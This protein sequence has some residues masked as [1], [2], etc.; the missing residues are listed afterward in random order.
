MKL[1]QMV[2]LGA[3]LVLGLT[4]LLAL[5]AIGVFQRMAPAITVILGRNDHSIQ[6]CG[7]MLAA[8]I[9]ADPD[10]APAGPERQALFEAAF[11]RASN[12]VTEPEEPA[13]LATIAQASTAALQGDPEARHAATEAI[14]HLGDINREAMIQ[15]D[16]RAR[17][18]GEAGAWGIVFMAIVVALA[19][20]VFMRQLERHVVQP[21]AEL[22]AVAL[23]RSNGDTM[24]RCTGI[25]LPRDVRVIFDA[26]NEL[27]DAPGQ[28]PAPPPSS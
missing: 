25:A 13:A 28:P 9:P 15:A 17:R 8:L 3:W 23:A 18:L 24:R 11:A 10:L 4:L 2:R 19:G 5:G 1:A 21:L 7:E 27:L 16:Q 14:L 12:N 22:H 26:V 6:A 20:M